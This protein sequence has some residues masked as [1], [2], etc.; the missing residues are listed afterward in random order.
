MKIV[1]FD[2][3]NKIINWE[4]LFED[5]PWIYTDWGCICCIFASKHATV[6]LENGSIHEDVE[7]WMNMG[8]LEKTAR[9]KLLPLPNVESNIL[10]DKINF[11]L[12]EHRYETSCRPMTRYAARGQQ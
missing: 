6:R 4:E 2:K 9:I 1:R 12:S 5:V 7:A 11:E 10:T 8:S 3:D